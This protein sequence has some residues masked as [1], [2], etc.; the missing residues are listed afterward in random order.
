MGPKCKRDLARKDHWW[1]PVW[2]LP[3]LLSRCLSLRTAINI[4]RSDSPGQEL[5]GV[6]GHTPSWPP[7]H[8]IH[9]LGWAHWEVHEDAGQHQHWAEFRARVRF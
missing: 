5:M 8:S 3:C 2:Q 1:A 4:C 7:W 9:R 6:L